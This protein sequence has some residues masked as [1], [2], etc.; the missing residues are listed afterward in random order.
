MFDENIM[1]LYKLFDDESIPDLEENEKDVVP[2]R[3]FVCFR[4]ENRIGK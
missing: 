1:A 3:Y 2:E 4:Y